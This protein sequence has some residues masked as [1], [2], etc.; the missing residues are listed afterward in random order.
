MEP[1]RLVVPTLSDGL[2]NRLFQIAVARGLATRWRAPICFARDRIGQ[3]SHGETDAVLR[4]F[5]EIPVLRETPE[6]ALQLDEPPRAFY[7][8]LDLGAT[9]P[10]SGPIVLKGYWQSWKYSASTPLEPDWDNGVG[11]AVCSNLQATANLATA[12]ERARTWSL[13]IRLGDY[14]ILPH[15]H[16]NTWRYVSH[17]LQRVP[18]G[19]RVHVFSDD[20]ETARDSL[21]TL[22][23]GLGLELTWSKT[24]R[25]VE[26][27]YEM[28]LCHG[29]AIAA[30]ST[31]SYWGATFARQSCP[32]PTA[33]RA[34]MPSSMGM[35][36]PDPTDYVPPWC[37]TL[38]A[39]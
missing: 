34:F 15:H 25:D 1:G 6:Q 29:G 2:G 37:S 30:N 5:P 16:I 21:L 20:I 36:Q 23:E 9:Y 13:H 10:A 31:F 24:T 11:A 14:T 4:L 18:R 39:L 28:S 3:N 22:S 12:Q 33:F 26:A 8:C 35:G 7:T 32:N 17:A 27:L 38:P 19:K